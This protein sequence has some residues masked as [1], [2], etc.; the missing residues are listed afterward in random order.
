MERLHKE[1]VIEM[2]NS[3]AENYLAESDLENALK[4]YAQIEQ[5]TPDS[6][7]IKKKSRNCLN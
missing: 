2:Y 6:E 3:I 4:Y 7:E 1:S 5:L